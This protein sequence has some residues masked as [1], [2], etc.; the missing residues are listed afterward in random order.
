MSEQRKWLSSE[1]VQRLK[2][3]RE[4]NP[5]VRALA[6]RHQSLPAIRLQSKRPA[7]RMS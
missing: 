1:D 3:T 5:L 4:G 6:S 2:F 7:S